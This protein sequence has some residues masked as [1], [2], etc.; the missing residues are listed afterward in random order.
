MTKTTKPLA[1]IGNVNVDLIVGPVT[2]WPAAGT[3][4][5]V[6]HDELRVGGQA[7]NSAL[8]WEALGVAYQIAANV[9]D[10]EFGRWLR[11][12]FGGKAEKWPVRPEH[13]TLSVGVTHP[14][15]ER[16]FLTTRGHLPRFSLDDVLAVLDG[17]RLAGGYALLGAAFLTDDY[18]E[19]DVAWMELDSTLEPTIGPYEVY[20]DEWFNAK[21]AFEARDWPATVRLSRYRLT[22]YAAYLDHLAPLLRTGLPEAATDEGLWNAAEAHL[23]AAIAHR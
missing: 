9:G 13:T 14:N 20:E 8:A 18:Y 5:T 1:V 19:S 22:L 6:D 4:I 12:R 2:P 23:L 7:G 16:T 21:A 3:E 10:D 11:A 17:D 15:G